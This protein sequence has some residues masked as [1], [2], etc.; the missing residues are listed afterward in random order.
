MLTRANTWTEGLSRRTS[1]GDYI[2]EL[3]GLRF[4]AVGSV[5]VFHTLFALASAYHRELGSW[6]LGP[7]VSVIARNP[8]GVQ[9]F[10]VISGFILALPFVRH[11]VGGEKPV[12][13]GR[14]YLRRLTRLEPP[15]IIALL[16]VFATSW[17]LFDGGREDD[18]G[19][20]FL[21]L[22]YGYGLVY[23]RP[24]AILGATW[25]LEIEVQ[26]YLLVPL[27][28]QIFR[29][30]GIIRRG[31]LSLAVLGLPW[32]TW[33]E[34]LRFTVLNQLAYF[35][36]GFLLADLYLSSRKQAV[37]GK[38]RHDWAA[39]AVFLFTLSLPIL[40]F[41]PLLLLAFLFFMFQ[42]F[43]VRR[44]FSYKPVYLIGGMCYSIYL[45]HY[46]IMSTFSRLLART[47]PGLAFGLAVLISACVCLPMV[48]AVSTCFF[49]LIERPCM[50]SRW[51][52]KLVAW[53][54]RDLAGV[55]SGSPT[56]RKVAIDRNQPSPPEEVRS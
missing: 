6:E 47:M 48:L 49:V 37:S 28:A 10:F 41:L 19:T 33:P 11:L 26:F 9:L 15:Y 4:L 56:A 36:A 17:I 53:I 20:F 3:D 8:F 38:T 34:M 35:L 7:V 25:T 27:L 16:L 54:K 44:L 21:R 30:P 42:G 13:I 29:L 39:V 31:V 45:M 55:A 22:V 32:V 2:P 40:R 43:R 12:E 52:K 5:L 50:D 46:P 18:L 23:Q 24:P 51:P 14:Y 1:G